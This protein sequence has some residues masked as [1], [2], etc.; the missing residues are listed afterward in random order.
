MALVALDHR[1]RADESPQHRLPALWL[2][3]ER[4]HGDGRLKQSGE[5][6]LA[7][8]KGPAPEQA[9]GGS[10]SVVRLPKI[11]PSTTGGGLGSVQVACEI[12]L[13]GRTPPPLACAPLLCHC[14]L[15]RPHDRDSGCREAL[16]RRFREDRRTRTS[17]RNHRGSD[18][19]P[20]QCS[21]GCWGA[22]RCGRARYPA[23]AAGSLPEAIA[24]AAGPTCGRLATPLRI[25]DNRNGR[26]A[27][28]RPRPGTRRSVLMQFLAYARPWRAV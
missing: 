20:R 21:Q 16:A 10:L 23:P 1:S 15:R 14:I 12:P 11:S 2:M 25:T 28:Q 19:P 17:R 7:R 4:L 3:R 24:Q 6:R 5:R 8:L 27:Q 22:A 9:H 18:Q 26:A 13:K